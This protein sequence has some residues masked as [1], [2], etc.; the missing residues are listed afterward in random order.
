LLYFSDALEDADILTSLETHAKAMKA[1]LKVTRNHKAIAMKALPEES[2]MSAE[3][4]FH[5]HER[6][7]EAEASCAKK[8]MDDVRSLFEQTGGKT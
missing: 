7:Y 2:R 6:Y 4:I 5:H 3:A 8:N 1:A